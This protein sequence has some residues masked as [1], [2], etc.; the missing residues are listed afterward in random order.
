M[1]FQFVKRLCVEVFGCFQA[2]FL[3][4]EVAYR[5]AVHGEV[6]S[7]GTWDNLYSALFEAEQAF[8]ADGFNLRDDDVR[9]VLLNHLVERVAVKHVENL[10]LVG[11]L[12]SRSTGVAVAGHDVLAGPFG[13]D[14]KL[15]AQFSRA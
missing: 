3:G 10:A 7:L 5:L 4:R 13:G 9:T 6:Y 15:F 8:R 2:E 11:H 12:H 1:L 14:N